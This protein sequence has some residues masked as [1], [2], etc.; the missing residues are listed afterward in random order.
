MLLPLGLL[1]LLALAPA[2]HALK[3]KTSVTTKSGATRL[4]TKLTNDS[5]LGDQKRPRKVKIK[6]GGETYKLSKVG[7]A[8]AAV[9]KLGTWRSDAYRGAN[10]QPLLDLAGDRVKVI[11]KSLSGTTTVRS[12]IPALDGPAP[13]PDPDPTPDPPDPEPGDIEGQE[14]IDLMTAELRGTWIHDPGN[15]EYALHMCE[16]GDA[17]YF[18]QSFTGGYAF[19]TEKFGN[20]WTIT[21]AL[22]R[23]DG[24][25]G[26]IVHVTW[27]SM[28]DETDTY[29]AINESWQTR[30]EYYD[31][32]WYWEDALSTTGS[33]A[34]CEETF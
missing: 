18:S 14:A 30:I 20:P 27:T 32:Q 29:Q 12:K 23:Q 33:P 11:V 16:N 7:G 5:P 2:A 31:G 22:I 9:V 25:K 4:V 1:A 28:H 17:R 21:E 6:G 19:A 15:P 13:D 34:S 26:A 10:A 3:A 24:Y 8:S